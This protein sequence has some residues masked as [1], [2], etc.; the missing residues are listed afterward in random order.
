MRKPLLR[1]PGRKDARCYET[2]VAVLDTP[3]LIDEHL[4]VFAEQRGGS[5]WR[6]RCPVQPDRCARPR[7]HA[8]RRVIRT[9]PRVDRREL[10]IVEH[11]LRI[12]YG[13]DCHAVGVEGIHNVVLF[14]S[15]G[16]RLK[17]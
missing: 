16:P 15:G 3:S 10:W 9:H 12:G 17:R 6:E 5:S 7:L 2:V 13:S 11:L 8:G 4:V 14:A 1:W